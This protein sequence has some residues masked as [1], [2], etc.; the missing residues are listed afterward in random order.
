MPASTLPLALAAVLLLGACTTT[1]PVPEAAARLAYDGDPEIAAE[2][3][4]NL[5]GSDPLVCR[6][7]RP[8]GSHRKQRVC[9]TAEDDKRQRDMV[10]LMLNPVRRR[11]GTQY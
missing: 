2:V 6:V 7:E 9:L 5:D 4:R 10:Q 1:Q 3:R 11:E 8:T